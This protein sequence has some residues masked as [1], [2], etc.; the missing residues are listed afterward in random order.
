MNDLPSRACLRYGWSAVAGFLLMGLMLESLH[1]F[2]VPFYEDVRLRRELWTLAHAH[3][4]LLGALNVLFAA[5]AVS[6][7]PGEAARLRA[8]RLLRA[9]GVLV[10]FGFLLG[11]IGNAEGDPSLFI[12][13]V[14]VGAV[15]A[16]LGT[17]ALALGALRRK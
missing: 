9:G 15:L 17:G 1:L 12:G 6:C 11:G 4:T 5:T 10:P 7:I 13:I 8:S 3:G 14:P 2:K 16:F